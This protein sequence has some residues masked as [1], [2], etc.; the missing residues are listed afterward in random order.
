MYPKLFSTTPHNKDPQW[1][2]V[3]IPTISIVRDKRER[4]TIVN[5]EWL[6]WNLSFMNY[7]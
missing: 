4:Y 1:Q 3:L 6:F 7:D 5:L 2:I